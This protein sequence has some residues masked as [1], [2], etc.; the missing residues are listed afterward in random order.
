MFFGGQSERDTQKVAMIGYIE[1]KQH[2]HTLV[3]PESYI[4]S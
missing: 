4:I 1:L 3:T 2:I